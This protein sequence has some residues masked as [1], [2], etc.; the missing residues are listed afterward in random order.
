MEEVT[1][2]PL[3]IS[4]SK[5]ENI[6]ELQIDRFDILEFSACGRFLAIRHQ[7]YPSTL[8]ILEVITGNVDFLLLQNAISSKYSNIFKNY[9]LSYE[10]SVAVIKI[11]FL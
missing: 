11:V 4:I 2:R 10:I 1:T 8:W 5:R 6:N 7:I 9:N 3:N